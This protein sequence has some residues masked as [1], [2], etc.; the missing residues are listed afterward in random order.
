MRPLIASSQPVEPSSG[1]RMRIA[2]SSSYAVPSATSLA[3]SSCARSRRSSWNVVSPSQSMPSQRSERSICATDSATSRLVSV[4]SIRSRHSPPRPRAKSQLKRNVRTPPMWRKPV[5]EGAM[6]T[7]TDTRVAYRRA[8]RR[9][10]LRGRRYLEGDRPDRGDRRERGAGLH[11]EPADV[12]TD[13]ARAGG[14][15]ALPDA[16]AAGASA[17]RLLSCPV[18]REP[19]EP[20]SRDSEEVVRGAA[21]DDGDGARDRGR[22]GR[23]PRRLASRLRLRRRGQEGDT[24]RFTTCSS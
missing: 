12:E 15:R 21:S 4:F 7:R 14:A 22:R 8:F 11:P 17:A 19:R 24:A 10:C 3:A 13:P 20:R 5:G 16:Q 18:P 23:L 2:P 1:M 9:P 6:R